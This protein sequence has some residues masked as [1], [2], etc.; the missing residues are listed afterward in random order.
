MNTSLLLQMEL[1]G[2][3]V[4]VEDLLHDEASALNFVETGWLFGP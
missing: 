4:Y 3:N 2:R 1:E